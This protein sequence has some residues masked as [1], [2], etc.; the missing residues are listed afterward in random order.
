[1]FI[2]KII[3]VLLISVF[4][5]GTV[6]AGLFSSGVPTSKVTEDAIAPFRAPGDKQ[7]CLFAPYPGTFKVEILNR[8]TRKFENEDWQFV[9][10][11]V[12]FT[13]VDTITPQA[14]RVFYTEYAYIQRGNRWDRKEIRITSFCMNE[15]RYSKRKPSEILGWEERDRKVNTLHETGL[16]SHPYT[17]KNKDHE[18]LYFSASDE[19]WE[20]SSEIVVNPREKAILEDNN[21]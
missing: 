2:K 17:Y 14:V 7:K 9:E 3:A 1:M 5:A 6:H 12:I 21:L 16:P 4:C 19:T 20:L 13:G 10:V 8:Y 11:K 18:T 15:W